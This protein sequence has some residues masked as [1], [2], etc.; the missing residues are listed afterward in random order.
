MLKK[1]MNIRIY[2]SLLAFVLSL[3]GNAQNFIGMHK[4]EI[5]TVMKETQKNFRLDTEFS[6]LKITWFLVASKFI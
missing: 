6:D 3:H 5:V 2:I 4:N 1:L